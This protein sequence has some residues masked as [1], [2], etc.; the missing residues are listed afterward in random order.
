MGACGEAREPELRPRRG[1]SQHHVVEQ[2]VVEQRVVEQ[3]QV[4]LHV[5][6][7]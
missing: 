2:R 3:R 4:R 5:I 6:Q 7:R 1:E